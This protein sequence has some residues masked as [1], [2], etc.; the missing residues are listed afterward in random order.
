M[1]LVNKSGCWQLGLVSVL[2]VSEA[3]ISASRNYL[4]AQIVPDRTLG[5]ESSAISP[6]TEVKGL[7]AELIEGGAAR[8]TNLFHSFAE[9]NV[10][11]LQRVYFANPAGIEKILSRVTGS[12]VSNILGTLGVDGSANLFFLNPN[13][14]I[15]GENAQLDIT[16]SFFASTANSPIWN[17]GFEFSA[18]NPEIPPLLTINLTPGLQYGLGSTI[19]NQGNLAAGQDLTLSAGN[20]DL[21]G[22]LDAGRDLKLLALDTV[23][24]MDSAANPFIAVADNQLLVQGNQGIDIFALNHPASGFFSGGDTILRSAIPVAGDAN[25]WSGGNFQSEQLDGSLGDLLSFYDPIIRSQGEVSFQSYQGASLHILAGGSVNIGSVTINA[26]DPED[27]IDETVTLSDGTTQ[28]AIDGSSQPT[29]D[30]RAGT[31]AVETPLG[32]TGSPIPTRIIFDSNTTPTANIAIDSINITQPNGLVFLTNQYQPNTTTSGE[33]QVGEILTNDNFGGF[34]GNSGN[35][36]IDSRGDITLPSFATINTSSFTGNAGDVHLIADRAISLENSAA[37]RSGTD[38]NGRGGDINIQA[39]TLSLTDRAAIAANTFGIGQGGNLTVTASES[40]EL[41]GTSTLQTATLGFGDAGDLTIAT[42]KLT[43]QDGSSLATSTFGESLGGNSIVNAS[44]SVELSGTSTDGQFISGIFAGTRG[45][46]GNGGEVKIETRKLIVSDGAQIN[47]ISTREGRGGDITIIASESVEL[48]G[49]PADAQ[50]ANGVFTQTF[51]AGDG[52]NLSIE[53]EKLVIKDGSFVS[54]G[55]F[56]NFFEPGQEDSLNG[57]AGNVTIVA[58]ESV[59]LSGISGNFRSNASSETEGPGDA[60][61]VRINTDKLIIRDGAFVSSGTSGDG[62]G[63]NLTVTASEFVELNG[64]KDQFTAQL[65]S[66]TQGDGNAGELRINTESLILKDG[67]QVSVSTFGNGN[68]G[69]LIVNASESVK[70]IGIEPVGSFDV[71]T[72]V[73]AQAVSGA[74]GNGG[75]I[76]LNT[77]SLVATD[78]SEIITRTAGKGNAGN[79]TLKVEEGLKITGADTGIFADTEQ[80]STGDGG[81]IFIDPETIILKDGASIAVNSQGEGEGGN[82]ELQAGSLALERGVITAETASN[83]GGNINLQ[84]FDLLTLRNSSQISATAGTSQAEGDGGNI[85]I[86]APFILSFPG[87]NNITAE[88]FLGIGGNINI[89]TNS[90]FGQEFLDISAS[91]QFGLEGTVSI[92]TSELD[93]SQGLVEL[94]SKLETPQIP[95]GCE[96]SG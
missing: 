42:G 55:A 62:L 30:I 72:G 40:V 74:E 45:G 16:G 52:G 35:V 32:V 29:L 39:R 20:L 87:K 89:T 6:N 73:F 49:T 59:A 65:R 31:T 24:I 33:I 70:I 43:L 47:T 48:L 4:L 27:S 11:E 61:E 69:N 85:D 14:I 94:P 5:D 88:A 9:F 53:T 90:I 25:Y 83:Q 92:D 1:V 19:T 8:G 12:N 51:G 82:I 15:F 37:I 26:T 3:T 68:A 67:G 23:R 28:V 95:Q 64:V 17:N 76:E 44:E 66:Q 93:P 60:G 71:T 50:L 13:G 2:V 36:I 58:T 81:S 80:G 46:S 57:Q 34:S 10:G 78:G 56:K 38:G 18:N 79:I 63:G 77:R 91:S 86:D 75:S 54:S 84:L 21:Q 96:A 22:Q 7:P 41:T